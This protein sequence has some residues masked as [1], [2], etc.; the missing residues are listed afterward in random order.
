MSYNPL[1]N[2]HGEIPLYLDET[3]ADPTTVEV[4]ASDAGKQYLISDNLSGNW[5][6][7]LYNPTG[8]NAAQIHF[9]KTD[10]ATYTFTL[11]ASSG[12][13]ING[14]PSGVVLTNEND[15][16]TIDYPG[17]GTV[18]NVVSTNLGSGVSSNALTL[19][20]T[21]LT[22]T[23]SGV[24]SNGVDVQPLIATPT[25]NDFVSV[26]SSGQVLD[27]GI[28]LSTTST[29]NSDTVILSSKATQTAIQAQLAN[30]IN[31][32]GNWDA[33]TNTPTL[34]AGTGTNGYAYYV[35]VAGT[36]TL[37]S[38][39]ATSYAVGDLVYYASTIWNKL[40][41]TQTVSS[42]FGRIGAVTATSGDYDISQVTNGLSEILSD[43]Q[44]FV[45][46]S[47]NIATPVTMTGDV[48]IDDTGATTLANSGV[49]AGSYTNANVTVDSKGRIT[50]VSN[51][52]AGGVTS[53]SAGTTG[54]TP[55][56]ATTGNIVLAGTL[57][58]A[59][60]GTGQTSQAAAITALT[61]T[62]T[63]GT[64]LRSDGTNSSLTAIQAADV[65]T[66]NQ[67]TTGSAGSI[68]ANNVI[69]N[70][71][72]SQ[73]GANTWKGN[74]TGATANE[75]DNA[76]GNLTETGSSIF[77]VSATNSLLNNATIQAN[78]TSANIY[79]GNI[80]NVPVGVAMSGGATIDN[81]GAVTLTNSAVTGQAL[82]GFSAN[83]GTISAT[84]TILTAVNKLAFKT[85][86]P[87]VSN[88]HK[89]TSYAMTQADTFVIFDTTGLTGTLPNATL[90]TPGVSYTF[91]LNSGVSTATILPFSGQTL[92]GQSTV[93]INGQFSS[94]SAVSDGVNWWFV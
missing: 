17:Q 51:G 31:L 94:L 11:L 63:A 25:A 3:I 62:Q 46:N 39:T 74:N 77:T 85:V 70:A 64:Y 60:G 15:Y 21:T 14:Y 7:T 69:T 30:T 43:A 57:A 65:P 34:Q 10:S 89:S 86:S 19:T 82:T 50:V 75:A 71:N 1:W 18:W 53:F 35:S 48:T 68:S 76:A 13:T 87:T 27:S 80:S 8:T 40:E 29:T 55:N 5:I 67:N 88:I 91:K 83:S 16:F 20:G 59:N 79:V 28:S 49:T 12:F 72:L 41:S 54:L 36:Q 4:L 61:G 33:S 92:D 93:T 56:S 90:V 32:Q 38:G 6:A 52:S 44:I 26:N 78:L 23:V 2:T 47:S 42:V 9:Q 37:P 22:S 45:G 73:A 66:L 81:T 58:I 24:T 84:D